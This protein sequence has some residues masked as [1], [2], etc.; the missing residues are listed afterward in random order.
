MKNKLLLLLFVVFLSS[1]QGQSDT[2]KILQEDQLSA[3]TTAVFVDNADMYEY[4]VGMNINAGTLH[5]NQYIQAKGEDGSVWFFQIKEIK[6]ND[7]VVEKA[8]TNDQAFVILNCNKKALSFNEGFFLTDATESDFLSNKLESSKENSTTT[9]DEPKCSFSI[10]GQPVITT[11]TV[12]DNDENIALHNSQINQLTMTLHG[13]IPGSA[14]RGMLTIII[15]NWTKEEGQKKVSK[16]DFV[17]YKDHAGNQLAVWQSKSNTCSIRIDAIE[18]GESNVL[19]KTYYIS[20]IWSDIDLNPGLGYEKLA[21]G[22]LNISEG[23]FERLLVQ[24]MYQR[25]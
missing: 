5:K 18:D 21:G 15:E 10:N 19:G 17:R 20:G 14:R 3:I 9:K 1:C 2:T 8:I 7:Q 24:E 12:K 6:V 11:P 22:P 16:T 23:K 4:S 13:D 25:D